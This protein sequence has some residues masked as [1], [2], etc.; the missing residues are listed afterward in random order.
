MQYRKQCPNPENNPKCKKEIDY[1]SKLCHSC[2][3]YGNRNP[4]KREDVKN[5][6]SINN[7]MKNPI[8]VLKI[9]GDRN[10]NAINKGK[11]HWNTGRKHTS[12]TKRLISEKTKEGMDNDRVR[13]LIAMGN[14]DPEK[15]KSFRK[16]AIKRIKDRYGVAFPNYNKNACKIIEEYGKKNGYNFQHAENG[17][18]FYIGELGYWVDGYD[19]EK[20]VVIEYYERHHYNKDGTLKARDLI[21]EQEIIN[22]LNCKF[23][24]INYK[25][26]KET[27]K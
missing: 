23:I 4:A 27:L 22:Y 24:S 14:K 12:E 8:H 18:E 15:I 26:Y 11:N 3:L 7:G 9:S 19:K 17:G 1:R 21:R 10:P 25:H 20:N 16:A 13:N 6:I 5:K 2:K